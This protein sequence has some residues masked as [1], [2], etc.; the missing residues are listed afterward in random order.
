MDLLV[1]HSRRGVVTEFKK[2]DMKL[3][4][5]EWTNVRLKYWT[6]DEYML[7]MCTWKN[8][9]ESGWVRLVRY[10]CLGAHELQRLG[11]VSEFDA[12]AWSDQNASGFLGSFC[13]GLSFPDRFWMLFFAVTLPLCLHLPCIW[14]HTRRIPYCFSYFGYQL[15]YRCWDR[16]LIH[17]C[18]RES[19]RLV[20][21][22]L[23]TF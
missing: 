9:D 8:F 7:P 15:K 21:S 10:C 23:N 16:R 11:A 6:L 14:F 13:L 20:I 4:D 5:A 1:W 17:T 18:V 2:M 19:L 12:S 3:A 22:D